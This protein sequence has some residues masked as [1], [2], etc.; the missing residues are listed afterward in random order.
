M[1][2]TGSIASGKSVVSR[3]YER[4]GYPVVYEDEVGHQALADQ[5]ILKK[6][7]CFFGTG[8]LGAHGE[9]DRKALG[10]IVFS[11]PEALRSLNAIVHPWMISQTLS[12]FSALEE[13]RYPLVFLEAAILYEMSLD[14]HVDSVVFVDATQKTRIQRLMTSRGY[15][16]AEAQKRVKAQRIGQ[17]KKKSDFVIRNEGTLESLYQ[18]CDRLLNV[19]L[20]NG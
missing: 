4:K 10:N 14:R 5:R 3:Y 7:I 12:R 20:A 13:T 19:L 17:Y 15:D 18:R 2:I 9:I 8:I 6:I 1:G 16:L 11:D